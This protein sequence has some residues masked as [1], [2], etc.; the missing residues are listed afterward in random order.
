MEKNEE[1]NEE[2]D[3]EK[4]DFDMDIDFSTDEEFWMKNATD[5]GAQDQDYDLGS[6]VNSTTRLRMWGYIFSVA[7]FPEVLVRPPIVEP[8]MWDFYFKEEYCLHALRYATKFDPYLTE[9]RRDLLE[10]EDFDRILRALLHF[11]KILDALGKP[12]KDVVRVIAWPMIMNAEDWIE[13]INGPK[14]QVDN[15]EPE[16]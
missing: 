1:K 8:N 7:T 10:G 5:T 12:S 3:E 4:R 15:T 9:V 13:L 6:H 2:E 16:L 11:N 14:R